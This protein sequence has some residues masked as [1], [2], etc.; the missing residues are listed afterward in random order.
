M[1][2][3]GLSLRTKAS[4]FVLVI[5]LFFTGMLGAVNFYNIRSSMNRQIAESSR[6]T[7]ALFTAWLQTG[8][9]SLEDYLLYLSA[10]CLLYTSG[11]STRSLSF[12]VTPRTR[13]PCT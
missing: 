7:L 11:R 12:T 1:N 4:L 9:D 6:S 10:T 13:P 2:R 8:L 3:E 5:L